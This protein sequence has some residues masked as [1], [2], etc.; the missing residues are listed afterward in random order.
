MF[1]DS[2][3]PINNIPDVNYSIY[4][5]PSLFHVVKKFLSSNAHKAIKEL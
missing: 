5:S 4:L 2:K 3:T 1:K